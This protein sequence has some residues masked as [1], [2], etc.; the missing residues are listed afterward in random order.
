MTEKD[1][2]FWSEIDTFSL[3]EREIREKNLPQE[4]VFSVRC[5]NGSLH[6]PFLLTDLKDRLYQSPDWRN[7][8]ISP[9]GKDYWIPLGEHPLFDQRSAARETL[10]QSLNPQSTNIHLNIKGR[11]SGPYSFKE[12]EEKFFAGKLLPCDLL[13]PDPSQHTWIRLFEIQ[14]FNRKKTLPDMPR[15]HIFQ[16]TPSLQHKDEQQQAPTEAIVNLAQLEKSTKSKDNLPMPDRKGGNTTDPI[17]S[18]K[19]FWNK[20]S[21]PII[22]IA[23]VTVVVAAIMPTSRQKPTRTKSTK[24]EKRTITKKNNVKP[25]KPARTRPVVKKKSVVSRPTRKFFPVSPRSVQPSESEYAA[26]EPDYQ[27]APIIK[28]RIEPKA[29]PDPVHYQDADFQDDEIL[30][31]PNVEPREL[32]D[33]DPSSLGPE[34]D[35]DGLGEVP[36]D[37]DPNNP[38][39]DDS[40][41]EDIDL[42]P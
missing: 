25:V 30:E 40:F 41:D 39:R 19:A 15:E 21:L 1:N 36:E 7:F 16:N 4:E 34:E 37:D 18:L 42:I 38:F 8:S 12:I 33:R 5:Q 31:D 28:Q 20:A 35:L 11:T 24:S 13:N 32:K 2:H 14:Y 27:E 17:E 26:E 10:L 6:G 22:G 3:S 29:Y 23:L 9:W